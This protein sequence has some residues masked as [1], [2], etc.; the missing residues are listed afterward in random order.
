MQLICEGM[1]RVLRV[2]CWKGF[3]LFLLCTVCVDLDFDQTELKVVL[4]SS[5]NAIELYF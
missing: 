2:P 4:F 1:G 3:F 5:V